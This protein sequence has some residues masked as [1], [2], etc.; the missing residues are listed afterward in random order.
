MEDEGT[1]NTELSADSIRQR[2][3]TLEE[4]VRGIRDNVERANAEE[5]ERSEYD[6]ASNRDS[7]EDSIHPIKSDSSL[8][9]DNSDHTDSDASKDGSPPD[10]PRTP[11]RRNAHRSVPHTKDLDLAGLLPLTSEPRNIRQTAGIFARELSRFKTTKLRRGKARVEP[12]SEETVRNVTEF[13]FRDTMSYDAKTRVQRVLRSLRKPSG[14]VPPPRSD[15]AVVSLSS[16]ATGVNVP[17]LVSNIVQIVRRI[18]NLEMV[19]ELQQFFKF[20][21]Q[22]E[23]FNQYEQLKASLNSD[24]DLISLLEAQGLSTSSGRGAGSC[25]KDMMVQACYG[26]EEDEK[27]RRSNR[28]QLN[29]LIAN[30]KICSGLQARWGYGILF[31][32]PQNCAT[33]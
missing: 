17:P 25:L 28:I 29:N 23:V 19:T 3:E 2:L 20:S 30:G 5:S 26:A 8:S 15:S 12:L 14:I 7:E 6:P 18:H 33:K 22:A 21:Y 11:H 27:R 4:F 9:P 13:M 32:L 31:L 10:E 24:A 16:S 1:L